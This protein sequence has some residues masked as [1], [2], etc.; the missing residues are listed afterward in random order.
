MLLAALP[1]LFQSC[2][3]GAP[4]NDR[5]EKELKRM[6]LREKIGQLFIVRP[7]VF[8]PEIVWETGDDLVPYAIR[9]VNTR[10]AATNKK[11]PVGGILLY[12]H[13]IDTPE[14]VQKFIGELRRFKGQP[15]ICIDEEGGRVARIANNPNFSVPRFA[16]MAAIGSTED[17]QAAFNAAFAIGSYLKKYG[18]DIDFA[19]VADVNTN[20]QNVIIGARAFSD[21]P[22][23]AAPMVAQYVKGMQAAGI[24]SCLKH[25]PGHGDT[26]ADT[27]LGYAV[28]HKTWE[29]MLDCEMISFKAG[30]AAGV[31]M[32]MSAHISAPEVTGSRIPSTLSPIILQEK[33]RGEL[34][35]EGVIITDGMEMGAITQQY[36][37][38]EAAILAIRAGADILL[39]PRDYPR[40]FDAVF[41][42]VEDGTIPESRIDES[43]RRILALREQV[44]GAAR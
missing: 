32:I 28:S 39:C 4:D 41:Q 38:E 15:L 36:S 9:S 19:P 7:E 20:P 18:F 3:A 1:L 40:V 6:T 31:P 13:N 22:S 23:V 8:D 42:A 44:R 35:F 14:Q 24:V 2:A 10:M 26:Y 30:I 33:L 5:I 27:H 21:K 16:S 12:A 17:P 11:Y 25:F 43:V 37:S 29:E 34:G